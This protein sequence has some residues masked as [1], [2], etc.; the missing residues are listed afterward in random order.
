M[1]R[2]LVDYV[3][4]YPSILPLE[5]HR[6]GVHPVKKK[7]KMQKTSKIRCQIPNFGVGRSCLDE[8]T[9]LHDCWEYCNGEFNKWVRQGTGHVAGE[10]THPTSR[11][12]KRRAPAKPYGRPAHACQTPAQQLSS[13]TPTPPPNDKTFAQQRHKAWNFASK[14]PNRDPNYLNPHRPDDTF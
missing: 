5:A 8:Y 7:Q 3:F 12:S 2:S 4:I 13:R 10:G 11:T 1:D 9:V 14:L 6:K